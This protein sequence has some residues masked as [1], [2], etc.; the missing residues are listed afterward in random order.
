MFFTG[1]LLLNEKVCIGV[2]S[3]KSLIQIAGTRQNGGH[4]AFLVKVH[5]EE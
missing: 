1:E 2:K 3:E 4:S 5:Y